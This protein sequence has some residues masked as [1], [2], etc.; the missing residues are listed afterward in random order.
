MK[1]KY[2]HLSTLLLCNTRVKKNK[3]ITIVITSNTITVYI[4]FHW[5]HCRIREYTF[6]LVFI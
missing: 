6:F 5:T 1:L 3:K 4:Y 2:E